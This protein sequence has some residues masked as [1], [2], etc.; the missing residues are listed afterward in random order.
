MRSAP[1]TLKGFDRQPFECRLRFP[2]PFKGVEVVPADQ[3]VTLAAPRP[4]SAPPAKPQAAP[5]PPPVHAPPPA[6]A[7]APA[8]H[9]QADVAA[10][11]A[12]DRQRI[13]AVLAECRGDIAVFRKE[14]VARIEDLQ[15]VAVELALTISS[16]LLH[17]RIVANDFPIDAKVRDMLAQLGDD[18]AVSVR[19]NPAD[20][21]LL[22]ARLGGEPLSQDRDDP[23]LVPDPEMSRGGCRVEGHESMLLSDVARE[24]QDIREDLLGSLNNARS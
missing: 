4:T 2:R 24:L 8:D 18:V 10:E 13:E 9:S 12:A 22:R 21:E 1:I 17:E 14:R 20:L 23:R 6:P 15:R 11:L 7:L 16:R 19:L 3:I 5:T